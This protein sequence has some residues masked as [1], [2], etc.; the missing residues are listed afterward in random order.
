MIEQ[1]NSILTE[2]KGSEVDI[3]TTAINTTIN[4]YDD[5]S[6]NFDFDNSYTNIT[7]FI[8]KTI[9]VN[10]PYVVFE[11]DADNL[12]I[13]LSFVGLDDLVKTLLSI[14]NN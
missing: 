9:E 7:Q 6:Y 2:I 8:C 11:F 13:D 14:D 4:Y 12:T 3:T 10:N 1:V 5:T